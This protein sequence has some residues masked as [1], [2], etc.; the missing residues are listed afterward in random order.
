MLLINGKPEQTPALDRGLLYGDGVF[1]TLRIIDGKAPLWSRHWRRLSHGLALL[2]MPYAPSLAGFLTSQLALLG[3]CEMARITIT[4]DNLGRGY[5]PAG[6]PIKVIVQGFTHAP[7]KPVKR[8]QLIEH[9]LSHQPVLLGC[10]N[11][12]RLDQVL[13]AQSLQLPFDD[14]VM[15]DQQDKV[16]CSTVGNIFVWQ[17]GQLITP[18]LDRA[19]IKGVMRQLVLDC[20]ESLNMPVKQAKLSLPDLYDAEYVWVSN[21]VRGLTPVA[22]LEQVHYR[23]DGLPT[24]PANKQVDN[25][26]ALEN[27]QTHKLGFLFQLLEEVRYGRQVI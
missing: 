14:G 7:A 5:A 12:N 11:L 23:L 1:E 27:A 2:S 22:Q 13:G 18:I 20:A 19:G 25:K 4:R 6:A 24:C 17:A 8:L 21:A 10:K 3:S 15:L 9:R 16:T 26:L